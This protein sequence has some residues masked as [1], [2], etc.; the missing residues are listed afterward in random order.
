MKLLESEINEGKV[1]DVSDVSRM[2]KSFAFLRKTNFF[3]G[4]IC[5]SRLNKACAA[6]HRMDVSFLSVI[7][8]FPRR[9][10]SHL[11]WANHWLQPGLQGRAHDL[12][13]RANQCPSIFQGE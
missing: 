2:K 3:L 8:S 10:G 5:A 6:V 1:Y 9:G 12:A 4:I 7:K 11:G 13:N